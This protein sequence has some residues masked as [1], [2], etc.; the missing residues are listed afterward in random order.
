[1]K[2]RFFKPFFRCVILPWLY[3]AVFQLVATGIHTGFQLMGERI[4]FHP[5]NFQGNIAFWLFFHKQ[6]ACTV[7]QSP[8]MKTFLKST[9]SLLLKRLEV[10]YL[11][12]KFISLEPC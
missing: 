6:C 8:A 4:S 12:L 7:R 10:Y 9:Y 5:F 2:N 11:V 1:C 3:S